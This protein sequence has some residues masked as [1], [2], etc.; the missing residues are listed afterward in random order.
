MS[1]S[2]TVTVHFSQAIMQAAQRLGLALPGDLVARMD[3]ASP[4][5][6]AACMMACEKCTVTVGLWLMERS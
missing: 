3:S 1:H 6:W 2:P 4:R 5:R